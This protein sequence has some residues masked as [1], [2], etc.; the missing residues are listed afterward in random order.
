[1]PSCR[2]AL[3]DGFDTNLDKNRVVNI[4]H[5][6]DLTAV[7]VTNDPIADLDADGVVNFADLAK[8]KSVFFKSCTP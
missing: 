7:V 8:T 4:V 2:D 1:M 3:S 5:L 6:A